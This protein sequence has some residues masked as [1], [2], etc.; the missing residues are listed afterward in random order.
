MVE[1]ILE[2]VMTKTFEGN[3]SILWHRWLIA[4]I[5]F[6]S[7][8]PSGMELQHCCILELNKK[9]C[10]LLFPLKAASL[11]SIT[12]QVVYYRILCPKFQRAY[13]YTHS[14]QK[15]RVVDSY[16]QKAAKQQLTWTCIL[17]LVISYFVEYPTK[18]LKCM[19]KHISS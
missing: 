13:L 4:L 17:L 16:K 14:K 9:L 18:Y 19:C 10:Y 6:T 5:E 2:T 3:T 11:Q 1:M 7:M 8:N 15:Y 12:I